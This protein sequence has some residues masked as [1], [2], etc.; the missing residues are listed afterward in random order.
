MLVAIA[1]EGDAL[2]VLH[3]CR[4]ELLPAG[5]GRFVYHEAAELPLP[6]AERLIESVRHTA[7]DA[8]RT[9][10]LSAIEKL[11]V[12]GACI[13]AGSASVPDS[14]AEVLRSH[15]RL[16]AAEGALYAGAIASACTHFGIPLITVRERDV[17]S[18]AS[19]NA[20]MSEAD[21]KIAIDAVRKTLGAPWSA[22]HKIATAAAICQRTGSVFNFEP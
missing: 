5:R 2:R 14:L 1:A 15:P 3:R 6:D 17:W 7:Q 10:M 11:K 8:A 18:R 22:D 19:A 21:L 9:A 16:H 20:G 12:I 13:P 4:M